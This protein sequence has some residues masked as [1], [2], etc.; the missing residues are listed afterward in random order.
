[1]AEFLRP[2]SASLWLRF[3]IGTMRWIGAALRLLFTKRVTNAR[4]VFSQTTPAH[5]CLI[6]HP[7]GGPSRHVYVDLHGGGFTD[8]VPEEDA[9]FCTHLAR[10]ASCTVVSAQYRFAP[11]HPY[12]TALHDCL[13]V[14][15]WA[16]QSLDATKVAIGGF[17][18]GATFALGVA[19]LMLREKRP[20]ASVIAFYPVLDFSADSKS[21]LKEK[22]PWIRDVFH[23]AYLLRAPDDGLKDPV[24]SPF[25]ASPKDLPESGVVVIPEID[26]NRPDMEAFVKNMQREKGPRFIGLFLPGAFHGWN[27]LSE[28]LIGK[29]RTSRKWE[30]YDLAV[31]E[32]KRAFEE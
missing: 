24:L 18:A 31:K 21:T 29:E 10:N 22:N 5:K 20:L 12:P 32:I 2:K 16:Q 30:S 3:R 27:L 26:P 4:V 8:G 23:E 9:E 13:A 7:P 28:W 11:E 1:M 19:Q 17:S 25:Y 6:F 14:V 15:K